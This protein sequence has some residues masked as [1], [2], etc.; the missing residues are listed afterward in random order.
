MPPPRM[1]SRSDSLRARR[2]R[3]LNITRPPAIRPGGCTRRRIESAVTDFPLPDS[4]TSASVS[5]APTPKLTRLT[6]ATGPRPVSN[7]VVSSSTESRACSGIDLAMFAEDAPHRVRDLADGGLRFDG[8]EDRRH[9]VVAAA[10]GGDDGVDRGSPCGMVARGTDPRH[11]L[12]LSRLDFG[13]DPKRVNPGAALGGGRR[14]V[15]VHAHDHARPGVDLLL[16]L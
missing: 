3:P 15:P 12:D 10:R 14:F 6:A 9:E 2:S 5:A 11:L 13:I 1:P 7:T 4:P 16:C 8:R